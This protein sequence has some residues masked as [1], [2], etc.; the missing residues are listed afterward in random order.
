MNFTELI[1]NLSDYSRK[2]VNKIIKTQS[3]LSKCENAITFNGLCLKEDLLP[4]FTNIYIYIYIY[5]Y[6]IKL[7]ISDG[8]VTFIATSSAIIAH[9]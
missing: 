4:K 6:L 2:T 5:I 8:F 3:K 1:V 7:G 9:S